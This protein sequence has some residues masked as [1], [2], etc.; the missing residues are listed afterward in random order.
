MTVGF[1]SEIDAYLMA[2]DP[3]YVDSD[4]RLDSILLHASRMKASDINFQTEEP[5]IAEVSGLNVPLTRRVLSAGEVDEIINLIYGANGVGQIRG[6]ND[7]DVSY[8]V[9]ASREE[10]YRYRVNVTGCESY[11]S[12]DGAQVTLRTINGNPPRL[13]DLAVEEAITR[14]YRHED[15]LVIV[16]GGTGNGKS[17]LLAGMMSEIIMDPKSH[18]KIIEFS[19]PIEFV[20]DA[21]PRSSVVISQHEIPRHLPSFERAVR[22][23]LR[24]APKIIYISESRDHQTIAAT[25]EASETGHA[26]YTTVHS[27]SVHGALYRMVNMFPSSERSTRMYEIIEAMR[28]IVVQKLV[29]RADGSGRLALRE[30]LVFDDGIREALHNTQSL[31][32]AVGLVATLVE[33]QGQTMLASAYD[34]FHQGLIN[35]S[36]VATLEAKSKASLMDELIPSF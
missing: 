35:R 23:A 24:R 16:C 25:L 8:S 12:S 20:Y 29:R 7:I 6:G 36:V 15:G 30:F 28:M 11:G 2:E 10:K 19:A 21:L 1:N 13:A 17:T 26:V 4:E 18:K 14:S 33:K 9:I 27:E 31:K 32:E 5:V 22:N 3:A 34:K